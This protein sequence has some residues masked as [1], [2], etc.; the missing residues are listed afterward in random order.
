MSQ[1]MD[2]KVL[3]VEE[4]GITVEVTKKQKTA[5]ITGIT[6][7]DAS[8]LAEFLLEKDYKVV[9]L[10]RRT[11]SP[12][13]ENIAAILDHP[14]F[15]IATGDITDYVSV[16]GLIA[17]HRP[18]EIY[19]L[20]AQ[21]FVKASFD[22]P[23]HTF[24]VDCLGVL[25]LLES[26]RQSP[27]KDE[28]RFYQASTSE[29]F[30]KQYD[31]RTYSVINPD[32]PD[33]KITPLEKH[34]PGEK[35]DIMKKSSNGVFSSA[36]NLSSDGINFNAQTY[37]HKSEK[38]QDEETRFVPQSPYGIAK[39]AAHHLVRLYRDSYK[40]QG[41]CGI[42]FNHESPR[43]GKDFVTRKITDYIGQL[44]SECT[45]RGTGLGNS[46]VGPNGESGISGYSGCTAKQIAE[47]G[48]DGTF[49]EY[50]G[51]SP[52]SW[53]PHL[54][55]NFPKLALGNL[56]AVR[57]WGHAQDF[58]E[59]QYLIL[60]QRYLADFVICTGESHSVREFCDI[61]FK[62]V[63]LNYKD[64]VVVDPKF[65]RP[66]EVDHLHGD[67]TKAKNQLRW[68]PRHTFADLVTEM[69]EADIRRHAK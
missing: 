12:N 17:E 15:E 66:S 1:Y 35:F 68:K 62:K 30:G 34:P 26:I 33:N 56:D 69:V 52:Y 47:E 67:C 9:G 27:R 48:V 49:F 64:F 41:A 14:N 61:A 18:D 55:R 8:Y 13:Y 44:V 37:W 29:M 36:Y 20:A 3:K 39:L 5:L 11:S 42:L 53:V 60:Q 10:K 16:S 32:H 38:Y 57:D 7:Q 45:I 59:A 65:Y 28:I 40:V 24:D 23:V 50:N 6:G 51:I 2:I 43:R 54:A 58:V 4:H 22:Q 21:S 19:N 46:S 63:G 25:N 31:E